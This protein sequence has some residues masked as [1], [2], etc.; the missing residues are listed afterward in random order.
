MY[1][2][3]GTPGGPGGNRK[4]TY[5][6]APFDICFGAWLVD[7]ATSRS[8]LVDMFKTV[9]MNLRDGGVF[10]SVNSPAT[11]DLVSWFKDQQKA[12]P[13]GTGG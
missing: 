8:T 6:S 10:V 12:R 11:N 7:H 13:N 4:I 9:A 2:M 1:P 3:N 5:A